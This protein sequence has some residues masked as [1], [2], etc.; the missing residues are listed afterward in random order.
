MLNGT[1]LP[2][3]YGSGHTTLLLQVLLVP[4]RAFF[5]PGTG[6]VSYVRAAFSTATH[7][8]MGVAMQRLGGLLRELRK[9]KGDAN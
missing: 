4:G 1:V 3:F 8:E 5:P 7:E 9:T 6:P 2:E